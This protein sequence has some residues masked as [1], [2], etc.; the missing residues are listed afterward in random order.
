MRAIVHPAHMFSK[1]FVDEFQGNCFS[2]H[3]VDG[4][5]QFKVIPEKINVNEK[6]VQ[7]VP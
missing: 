4:T 5:G 1:T 6:G 3:D 2:C 7:D